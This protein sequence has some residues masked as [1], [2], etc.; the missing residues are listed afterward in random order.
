MTS[1]NNDTEAI[2]LRLPVHVIKTIKIIAK[3]TQ[4]TED[5][6]IAILL[7]LASLKLD[8][9]VKKSKNNK[10]QDVKNPDNEIPNKKSQKDG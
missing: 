2:V 6:V 3:Q 8:I 1:S 4:T 10:K 7:L 5:Q 9:E